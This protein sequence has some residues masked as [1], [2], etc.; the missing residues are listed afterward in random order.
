MK[1]I[2]GSP[3]RAVYVADIVHIV[4]FHY[5]G[6][7]KAISLKHLRFEFRGIISSQDN[8]LYRMPNLEKCESINYSISDEDKEILEKCFGNSKIKEFISK[9]INGVECGNAVDNFI[10]AKEIID[11]HIKYDQNSLSIKN[12]C[13]FGPLGER[14]RFAFIDSDFYRDSYVLDIY[15]MI[16]D[17]EIEVYCEDYLSGQQEL[18]FN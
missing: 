7:R 15:K 12:N 5:K 6:E 9:R 10:Q 13:A 1:L 8:K 14:I 3:V 17:K 4:A 2:K 18:N 11:N 16:P